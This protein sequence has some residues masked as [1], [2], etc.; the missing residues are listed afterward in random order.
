MT[1]VEFIKKN[2]TVLAETERSI[3]FEAYGEK[4][5]EIGCMSFDCGSV[6]QFYE[7]IAMYG[8]PSSEDLAW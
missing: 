6:A 1:H 8:E 4:V 3:F 2:Y 7:L 5:A